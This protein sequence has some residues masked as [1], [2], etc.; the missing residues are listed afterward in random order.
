MSPSTAI[1]GAPSPKLSDAVGAFLADLGH[2]NRSPATLRAYRGDLASFSQHFAGELGEITPQALR[3]HFA[4]L[5]H[6]APATRAR[7]EASLASFLRWAYRN[8]LIDADPMSKLDRVHLEPPEPRGLAK[9]QVEAILGAIPRG[10]SRDR[11]LFRLLAE[12]GLRVGEALALHVDDIALAPDDERLHVLGKGGRR[13]TLLLDDPRLVAQIKRHLKETSYRH[14]PLFRAEKNGVGGPLRYSTVQ[15]HWATYCA[16]AGVTATI[17][18]LRHGHATE[19]INGGVSLPTIRKRLGHRNLQ[20]TLRYAEQAD[21][22]ADAELGA[23]RR[24][25]EA[26]S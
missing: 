7:R 16:K 5:V 26:G 18:Q 20:T 25:R 22:T 6:L 24:S 17:H 19:L 11:L 13:R 4:T 8:D 3:S 1:E 21:A 10:R 12:T 15:E 23:W 14:G 9:E 2:A